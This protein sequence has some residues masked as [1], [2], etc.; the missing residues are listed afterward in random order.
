MRRRV[1]L[2]VF[3]VG[4]GLAEVGRAEVAI[5]FGPPGTG[6]GRHGLLVSIIG[7]APD[8]FPQVWERLS[9]PTSGTIPL[10]P[11]GSSTGDGSPATLIHPLTGEAIVAWARN[12]AG[13]FDVVISR[14]HD[15]AW[16]EPIVVAGEL[17]D[18]IDPSLAADAEGT[19]HLVFATDGEDRGIWHVEGAADLSSWSEP[20]RVSE[21]GAA[22][23][24]PDAVVHESILR[25]VYESHDLGFGSTPKTIV[26]SRRE[27]SGFVREVVA[28]TGH[29][30]AASPRVGSHG[31]RL[32]VDWVDAVH[33][34]GAGELAWVRLGFDGPEP[35]GYLPFASAFDRE[36]HVRPGIRLLVVSP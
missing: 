13:S 22:A 12:T 2:L 28:T 9:S 26:L 8:P 31:G 1:A 14:F 20:V 33:A 29:A 17:V 27:G 30:G 36:F 6:S 5:P 15:G 18:E 3:L 11:N 10:N 24:R 25:V 23:S 16:V 32:W 21:P 34:T 4:F 19:I 7:D 35:P